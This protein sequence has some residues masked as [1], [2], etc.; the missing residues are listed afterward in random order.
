[1]TSELSSL[2]NHFTH[3]IQTFS[4]LFKSIEHLQISTPNNTLSNDINNNNNN[5]NSKEFSAI[6][7]RLYDTLSFVGQHILQL[8]KEP[9]HRYGTYSHVDFDLFISSSSF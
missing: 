9:L 2:Q 1:M 8:D 7:S 4:E 5:Q 6:L 3:A